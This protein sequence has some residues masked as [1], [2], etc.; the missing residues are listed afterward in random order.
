MNPVLAVLVFVSVALVGYALAVGLSAR[1]AQR[2]AFRDRFSAMTGWV[3]QTFQP[4]VLKD[5]RLS[6]IDLLN[7]ILFRLAVTERLRRM[8]VQAG[9]RKRV[10]EFMLYIPLLATFGLLLMMVIGAPF[11]ASL[12][13]ASIAGSIPLF[14]LARMRRKRA[15]SF[16]EQLPDALD[17]MRSALKAG[18]GLVSS[19]TLIADEFPDPIAT[20]FREVAEEVR[21]GLPM[22]EALHN[23]TQRIDNPDTPLLAVG[24]LVAQDVGGNLAEVLDNISYTI[25]ERFKLLRDMR[26]LT[27]QGRLS[28][29][30][31]TIL[32]FALAVVLTAM[33]PKYMKPVF[34]EPLGRWMI[35]YVFASV[36]VGHLFMRRIINFKV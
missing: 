31:L 23:L 4:S 12:L 3:A 2:R 16:A 26:V 9:V 15:A 34:E 36:G 33:N 7:T 35:I 24:L 28:G 10:G 20:E 1:V 21:L 6:R 22:R 5:Q 13:V 8:I 32:P 18:H 27:A 25:R 30:V 17:L 14:V 19:F 29:M 11:L